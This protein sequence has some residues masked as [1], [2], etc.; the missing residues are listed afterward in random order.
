MCAHFCHFSHAFGMSITRPPSWLMIFRIPAW[1]RP[2][3][4]DQFLSQYC[5]VFWCIYPYPWRPVWVHWS[6]PSDDDNSTTFVCY[7]PAS[8][9]FCWGWGYFLD[10]KITTLECDVY[11]MPEHGCPY[12]AYAIGAYADRLAG[13]AGQDQHLLAPFSTAP[14]CRR[15]RYLMI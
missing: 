4:M 11:P 1:P 9:H 13:I 15:R 3:V 12:I 10:M 2:L 7:I 8:Q 5:V 14:C 6:K